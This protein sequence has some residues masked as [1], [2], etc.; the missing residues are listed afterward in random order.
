MKVGID[1]TAAVWQGAGIGRYTRELIRA[2]VEQG[3]E[4]EY[5]LFYAA[6]QLAPDS[7]Y[8]A[9]LSRLCATHPNVRAVPIPLTPRRLT[10]IWQRLRLP[11]PV[12]IF[13]G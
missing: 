11:L 6:G 2:I 5:T 12:E 8:L 7:P 4:F 10:Q 1:Y 9:D 13:T 3:R